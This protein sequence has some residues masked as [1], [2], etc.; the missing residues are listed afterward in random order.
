[1]A[2]KMKL[3]DPT[4]PGQFV[5]DAYVRLVLNNR[6]RPEVNMG[7]HAEF[8]GYRNENAANNGGAAIGAFK[9]DIPVDVYSKVWGVLFSGNALN[10]A[11]INPDAVA[12]WWALTYEKQFSG[13]TPILEEGQTA[14]DFSTLLSADD[15]AYI[16]A[17][18]SNP[19][20]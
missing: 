13:A 17:K 12:Y 9:M 19:Q 15:K 18:L 20:P 1:M 3:P 10:P 11:N 4:D 8:L 14:D 2:F 5:D 6:P 16:T 7:L